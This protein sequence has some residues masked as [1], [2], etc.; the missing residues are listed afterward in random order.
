MPLYLSIK[1]LIF[2]RLNRFSYW[3][4]P[5]RFWLLLIRSFTDFVGPGVGW[6]LYPPL[7]TLEGCENYGINFL[8]IS[9]HIAGISSILRSINFITRTIVCRPNIIRWRSLPLFL[10]RIFIT[11]ILLIFALPVLAAGITILLIDRAFNT[12][13]FSATGGGDPILFQHLFWFFGHPEVYILILPAFGVISQA[14]IALRGKKTVF[15]QLGII[16][17]M[18]R[19]ALLGCV[20][21]AHHIFTVGI[22]IDR[23]AYFSAATIII[24]IPTGIKIFSWIST[25]YGSLIRFNNLT[26]WVIGFLFLFTIG[27]LTGITLR[28]GS[29]DVVLHDTYFVVGHFHYVLSIGAVFSVAVGIVLWF[30]LFCDVALN[31]ILIK[32]RFWCLFLGVNLTFFPHHFLGL[33]GMPRR[34]PVYIDYF[35]GFHLLRSFGAYLSYLSLV[36][37]TYA[38]LESL[39]IRVLTTNLNI[40]NREFESCQESHKRYALFKKNAF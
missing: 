14:I 35:Q 33:N 11:N 25:L 26:L 34:Y 28:S 31:E 19:I 9:L 4:I 20:V 5:L 7:S 10:W 13:F 15:G 16:Y 27:G 3:L 21:W 40:V 24:A 6:T 23:R 37:I 2:P 8:I 18:L 1:D 38:I 36:L 22:D 12:C 32:I 30:P 39:F 17:A 29:L